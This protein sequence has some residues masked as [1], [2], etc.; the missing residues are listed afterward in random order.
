MAATTTM[1]SSV[2][3]SRAALVKPFSARPA[4]RRFSVRAED[5]NANP[6]PSQVDGDVLSCEFSAS[7]SS[8][9]R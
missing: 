4:Q 6:D 8:C 9:Y 3:G 5:P 2:L 1:R 7:P